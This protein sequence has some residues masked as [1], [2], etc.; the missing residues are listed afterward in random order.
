MGLQW[1]V[2]GQSKLASA[3]AENQMLKKLEVQLA[4]GE[5]SSII[6]A[7]NLLANNALRPG[8]KAELYALIG[9]AFFMMDQPEEA[10]TALNK[11]AS[12]YHT[13]QNEEGQA[14]VANKKG[15]IFFF[16]NQL[17]SA[18]LLLAKATE[19]IDESANLEL[20]FDIYQNKAVLH[21][22][23]GEHAKSM[24]CLHFALNTALA[25]NDV[26]KIE[27][28]YNQLST[29][30]YSL[31]QLDSAIT[32]FDRLIELKK[33]NGQ[34]NSLTNDL[35]TVGRL[36]GEK[37]DYLKAQTYLIEALRLG[38][39]QQDT[40]LIMSLCTDIAANYAEQGIWQNSFEYS[41]RALDLAKQKE[42]SFITAQNLK[43]QGYVF[44]KQGFTDSA[45]VHYNEALALFKGLNN[46]INVA[47]I[48]L[49][50]SNLL[51]SRENYLPA[52]HYAK[53]ALRI[54]QYTDNAIGINRAKLVLGELELKLGNSN[55]A[56][57]LLEACFESSKTKNDLNMQ[58]NASKLI[59]EAYADLQEHAHAYSWHKQY[60]SLNDSI[61]SIE[62]RKAISELEIAYQTEQKD[63][64]LQN[65]DNQLRSKQLEIDQRNNLVLLLGIILGLVVLSAIFLYFIIL[66]NKQLHKQ[67]L[68][69]L[70]KQQQTQRLQA[71]IEGEEKERKRIAR[72][73]HDGLG[74]VL[75]TVKM[76]MNSIE[77][78]LPTIREQQ[79]YLKAEDLIDDACRT[80]REISHNMVPSVL[81]QDGLEQT[82]IDM[83]ETIEY[84]HKIQIDFIP[85]GLDTNLNDLLRV[86]IYRIIQELLRNVVKHAEAS[87]VIVQLTIENNHLN[88]IVEDDGKGFEPDTGAYK[89]GIGLD[90]VYSRVEYLEGQV[91]IDSKIGEGTTF[92]IDIPNLE[93]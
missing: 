71:L 76:R 72:D 62:Q 65:K 24:E 10:T 17:D 44:H 58:R 69:V 61:L 63:M 49:E 5:V 4:E 34:E 2:I 77:N 46:T 11:A 91:S 54:W 50:L 25:L 28:I 43:T 73:L 88:L 12:I 51:Q 89:Q 80:V 38:E 57:E 1:F 86:T 14:L 53:E 66:K 29:N 39:E 70:Q 35:S 85:F 8:E 30:Y 21:S 83:C 6:E 56:V 36:Y 45:L 37:G 90:N 13:L 82:I 18:Q 93:L 19:L 41:N 68:E 47:D 74:A 67:R 32:Y 52:Q 79:S 60:A 64:R 78:E 3:E 31:G 15:S 22:S 23:Q 55:A 26:E 9:E 87:E 33:K 75:A 48:Q 7:Q 40:F 27:S 92:T 42:Q 84:A 16:T 81:D 59:A 20:A